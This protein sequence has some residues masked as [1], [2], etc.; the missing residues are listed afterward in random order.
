MA[1]AK[2]TKNDYE[3]YRLIMPAFLHG[4]LDHIASNLVFQL[5]AGSGIEYGI[6]P[7]RM[8]ILY[9]LCSIG[10]VFFSIDLHPEQTAVGASCAGYGLLGFYFAYCISNYGYMQRQK[11]RPFQFWFLITLAIFFFIMNMGFNFRSDY[12]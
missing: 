11:E 6:G 3:Y 7:W 12:W 4:N 2:S 9:T 8:A 5:Y 1:D 10:G